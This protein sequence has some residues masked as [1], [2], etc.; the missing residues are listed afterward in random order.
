MNWLDYLLPTEISKLAVDHL[1][2]CTS[3]FSCAFN[4]PAILGIT[5]SIV[6]LWIATI[7]ALI[8]GANRGIGLA[9]ALKLAESGWSLSLG[10]RDPAK[11]TQVPGGAETL[12]HPF[13][14]TDPTSEKAWADATAE[15]FGRIDAVIANAGIMI[16]K[17]V[18]EAE[19]SDIDALMQ[20]NVKSPMRLVQ[21]GSAMSGHWF[22]S[23]PC[24][25][26]SRSGS[27][28][29][30]K[31]LSVSFSLSTRQG[32]ANSFS[33]KPSVPPNARTA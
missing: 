12:V 4:M 2:L 13:D 26:F 11:L 7:V 19:D 3:L 21:A 6:V 32:T 8:S 20:V 31:R 1:K 16:P 28:S 30:L 24:I 5:A 22:L 29:R 14:A 17:T 18:I 33:P 25:C 27:T 9:V 10:V 15:R 23:K